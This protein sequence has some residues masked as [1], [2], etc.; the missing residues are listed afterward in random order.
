MFKKVFNILFFNL[1]GCAFG[2]S[3]EV[4]VISSKPTPKEIGESCNKDSDCRLAEFG[5]KCVD[6]DGKGKICL[7][8]QGGKCDTKKQ[9]CPEGFYCT[10]DYEYA[11]NGNLQAYCVAK[12]VKV[13][14]GET[15]L[16][17]NQCKSGLCNKALWEEDK[18][19]GKCDKMPPELQ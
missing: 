9:L 17:N 14:N 8:Y 6:K 1:N 12:E 11:L 13:E 19:Y 2:F 10:S 4:S 16:V 18:R 15:C 3:S 5:S 7:G